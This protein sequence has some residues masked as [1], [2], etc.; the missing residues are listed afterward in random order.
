MILT[1]M[2]SEYYNSSVVPS[3][4]APITLRLGVASKLALIILPVITLYGLL[5]NALVCVSILRFTNLRTVG[6]YYI[7][8]LAIA[9]LLVCS[10]VLPLAIYQEVNNGIWDLPTWLCNVWISM[11]V[12]MSTA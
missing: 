9:D 6:N 7:M 12:L 1:E 10:I 8:A 3:D 4:G 5:G 11:D 2:S